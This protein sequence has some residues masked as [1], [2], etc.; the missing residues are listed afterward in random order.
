[1]TS[2][3]RVPRCD[4]VTDVTAPLPVT[5]DDLAHRVRHLVPSSRHPERFH[6]DKSEIVAELSRLAQRVRRYG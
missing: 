3:R 5:L 4:L 1:M 2:P 6:E